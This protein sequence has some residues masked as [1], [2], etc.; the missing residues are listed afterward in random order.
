MENEISE[1][2]NKFRKR[3]IWTSIITFLLI[4][5]LLFLV[6][7]GIL[8]DLE[9]FA[10]ALVMMVIMTLLWTSLFRTLK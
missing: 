8:S 10:I 3:G 2:I 4:P 7:K 6:P 9:P 1:K 5:V